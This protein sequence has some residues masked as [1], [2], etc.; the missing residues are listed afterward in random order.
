MLSK[1]EKA[2][3]GERIMGTI[4]LITVLIMTF[5]TGVC[6]SGDLIF[7]P[8]HLHLSFQDGWYKVDSSFTDN[9][10]TK[11]RVRYINIDVDEEMMEATENLFYDPPYRL[12]Q[13][14]CS[15]EI[16]IA[17]NDGNRQ[18]PSHVALIQNGKINELLEIALGQGPTEMQQVGNALLID[19][20]RLVVYGMR[21]LIAFD[22]SEEKP[23]PIA[24]TVIKSGS[25]TSRARMGHYRNGFVLMNDTLSTSSVGKTY[26]FSLYTLRGNGF[27]FMR[28]GNPDYPQDKILLKRP[29]KEYEVFMEGGKSTFAGNVLAGGIADGFGEFD[30]CLLDFFNHA[31]LMLSTK[32]NRIVRYTTF[33]ESAFVE[34]WFEGYNYSCIPHFDDMK[35]NFFDHTVWLLNHPKMTRDREILPV[36]KDGLVLSDN[37]QEIDVLDADL[38]YV[39]TIRF[40][41]PARYAH[42]YI[43]TLVITGE[44][45]VTAVVKM[46]TEDELKKGE[47]GKA[48]LTRL[49]LR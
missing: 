24:S 22:L 16:A 7:G 15:P 32:E 38:K 39:E 44:K 21:K 40:V 28:Q 19:S 1:I 6:Y 23:T 10:G 25:A 11:K 27:Q 49:L 42:F 48:Y 3:H 41:P 36:R 31:L 4:R 37:L 34:S 26:Y 12:F 18:L 33:R 9:T 2:I 13:S 5:F 43:Q 47:G 8:D 14:A 29:L 17:V 35:T 30:V 45:E 20:H 46:A